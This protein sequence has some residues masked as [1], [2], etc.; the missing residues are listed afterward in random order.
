V[1]NPR[2]RD[3]IR[4]AQ[5]AELEGDKARAVTLLQE[6]AQ[7]HLEAAETARAA[8]LLRHC[9]RLDPDR[10][11]LKGVLERAERAAP[12]E[13]AERREVLQLAERGPVLA[14]PA[15]DC[16]CSFCCPR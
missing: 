10:T 14:D 1:K 3:L 12:A 5:A 6:A 13:P 4:Q 9:L 8:A 11:D 7:L 16:W 15:L 2:I